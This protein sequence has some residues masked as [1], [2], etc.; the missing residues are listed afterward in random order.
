MV[1]KSVLCVESQDEIRDALR[2][3]LTGWGYRAL[4]VSDAERAAER[5]REAPV[6]A[7]IFDTDGQ[8]S[9]SIEAFL[10]MHEKAHEEGQKLLAVVLLGPNRGAPGKTSDRRQADRSLQARQDEAGP[11]RARSTVAPRQVTFRT[12]ASTGGRDGRQDCRDPLPADRGAHESP[13]AR[14]PRKQRKRGPSRS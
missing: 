1:P 8:G 3:S 4:L 7:V 5:F 11:G 12:P 6:D 13:P 2:K 9:E 10:D 14:L